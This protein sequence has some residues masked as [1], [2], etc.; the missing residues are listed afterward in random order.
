MGTGSLIELRKHHQWG[1]K[2]ASHNSG[3][4]SIV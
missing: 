1:L 2:D 3:K 4:F